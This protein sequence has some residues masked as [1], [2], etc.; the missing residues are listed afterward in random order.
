MNVKPA[1]VI[2]HGSTFFAP[3][4]IPLLFYF[5]SDHPYIKEKAM[6]ALLFHVL[7]VIA[8]FISSLLVIV[9][10]GFVLLLIFSLIGIY[11]PIKGIVYALQERP[12]HYPIVHGWV[13]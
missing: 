11:Y 3:V 10:I 8:L 9:L 12:F 7:M 1:C 13:K 6:E 4:L 2:I 5:L